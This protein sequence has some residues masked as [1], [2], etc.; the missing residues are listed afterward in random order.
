M[1]FKKW[2]LS[3]KKWQKN[4]EKWRKNVIHHSKKWKHFKIDAYSKKKNDK[5]SKKKQN[6]NQNL[7]I[8]HFMQIQSL[9]HY[10]SSFT[11]ANP[12]GKSE[13]ILKNKKVTKLTF[14]EIEKV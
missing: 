5:T 11:K 9:L 6:I 1:Y 4:S 8:H 10:H 2:C 3:L 12:I 7:K 14:G 13:K